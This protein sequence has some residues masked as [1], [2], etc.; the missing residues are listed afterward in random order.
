[1]YCWRTLDSSQNKIKRVLWKACAVCHPLLADWVSAQNH[2]FKRRYQWTTWQWLWKQGQLTF[3]LKTA[4]WLIKK[5]ELL[6][7]CKEFSCTAWFSKACPLHLERMSWNITCW[8]QL[9]RLD[10]EQRPAS[11]KQ[12]HGN[13]WTKPSKLC[14]PSF[15]LFRTISLQCQEQS[16]HQ[17]RSQPEPSLLCTATA[18]ANWILELI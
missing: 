3:R 4:E 15:L 2:G 9:S 1:M 13:S 17:G 7:F 5:R 10:Q 16:S 8:V 14:L 12:S 6:A 11:R 18:G